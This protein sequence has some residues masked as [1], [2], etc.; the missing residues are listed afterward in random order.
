[1][2]PKCCL[3]NGDPFSSTTT[4]MPFCIIWIWVYEH[5]Y[6]ISA[7]SLWIG[8]G[9]IPWWILNRDKMFSSAVF[10]CFIISNIINP[11]VSPVSFQDFLACLSNSFILGKCLG[12]KKFPTRSNFPEF[13]FAIFLCIALRKGFVFIIV[14]LVS[15]FLVSWIILTFRWTYKLLVVNILFQ[16][17]YFSL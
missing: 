12:L 15:N 16:I 11:N 6:T 1:M 4:I 5:W 2:R 10:E 14:T 7:S 13:F 9:A 8:A 3:T 17:F